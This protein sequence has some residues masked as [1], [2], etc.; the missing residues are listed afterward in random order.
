L[1]ALYNLH[2]HNA[3]RLYNPYIK[4]IINDEPYNKLY[5]SQLQKKTINPELVN[6]IA[7][8]KMRNLQE[9]LL[10]LDKNY[11][12]LSSNQL[13]ILKTPFNHQNIMN[14]L[15]Q[16][17]KMI[18]FLP[19]MTPM[20]NFCITSHYGLRKKLNHHKKIMHK[21]ID[22]ACRKN[23]DIYSAAEGVAVRV[24]KKKCYGKFID[25]KHSKNL[26]TRYAHLND[27]YIK[28][29]SKILQG[30]AIGSQGKT[31]NATGEHLHFEILLHNKQ[32][33]PYY[34]LLD[35]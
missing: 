27:I 7:H 24:G 10:K 4:K 13:L 19:L 23:C 20:Q 3:N 9:N 5:I 26:M 6:K 16:I 17:D 18:K 31:G 21:G 33:N 34:F 35:L 22:L 12:F 28:E 2:D 15:Q 14:R 29:G 30:Q 1:I 32:I 11:N 8:I 25:I